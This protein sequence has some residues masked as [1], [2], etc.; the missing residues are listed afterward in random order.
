MTVKADVA[1]IA[2]TANAKAVIQTKGVQVTDLMALLQQH[3]V[4]MQAIVRQVIALTPSGDAN[5][6]ALNNIPSELL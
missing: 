2:P 3:A 6:T 5:L 1:A 4:R